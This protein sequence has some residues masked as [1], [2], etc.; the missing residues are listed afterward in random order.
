MSF[1]PD[2]ELRSAGYRAAAGWRGA[3]PVSAIARRVARRRTRRRAGTAAA[4]VSLIGIGAVVARI[5][6]GGDAA[7]VAGTPSTTSA[8]GGDTTPSRA[9][10]TAQLVVSRSDDGTVVL[11]VE[12]VEGPG[13]ADRA[14]DAAAW[15]EETTTVD[16]VTV[17]SRTDGDR[18]IVAAA[19]S[20]ERYVEASGPPGQRDRLEGIVTG[21]DLSS[22]PGTDDDP[23]PQPGTDDQGAAGQEDEGWA[24]FDEQFGDQFGG[25]FDGG[26]F[27]GGEFDGGLGQWGWLWG[28]GGLPGEP[29]RWGEV[30][31]PADPEAP[32]TVPPDLWGEMGPFGGPGLLDG[33]DELLGGMCVDVHVWSGDGDAWSSPWS[34]QAG[35][36]APAELEQALAGLWRELWTGDGSF[37]GYDDTVPPDTV[38]ARRRHA[39]RRAARRRRRAL[40]PH[41]RLR[42]LPR[43]GGPDH[44]DD[45]RRGADHVHHRRRGADHVDLRRRG[46]D[47][48]DG[49]GVLDGPRA[50]LHDDAGAHQ[51]LTGRRAGYRAGR[52]AGTA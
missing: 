23:S 18:L 27:D 33:L 28:F 31:P 42:G 51:D 49:A 44:V 38:H 30:D 50:A 9:T 13:A 20:P 46:S 5:D 6:T 25:E 39:R 14:A 47:P 19:P 37:D 43:R 2:T 12:V 52:R 17:W 10:G 35:P 40:A 1:D 34:G 4:A 22:L 29:D 3:P 21:S 41:H 7:V 48:V 24:P 36:D 8:P 32:G 26:E 16:G 45:R 11:E 15:A